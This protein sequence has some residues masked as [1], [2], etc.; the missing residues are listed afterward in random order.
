[1]RD[2]VSRS[3]SRVIEWCVLAALLLI[4]MGVFQ[5]QMRA[6]QG[7]GELAAI[8]STLGAL[9]T[10]FVLEHIRQTVAGHAQSVAAPQRNP[11]LLLESVPPN[12]AGEHAVLQLESTAPGS[13]VFDP[14]CSCIGYVLLYP[15]WLETP[16]DLTTLWFSVLGRTGPLTINAVGAYVWQGQVV[17]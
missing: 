16:P 14:V 5:R 10:A 15:Q 3:G 11:F 9:R 2:R 17:N 7:R 13:W 8:Q 4:V 12:Y 1:M 6:V